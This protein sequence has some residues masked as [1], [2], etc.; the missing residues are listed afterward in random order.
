MKDTAL[1]GFRPAGNIERS[2]D[3]LWKNRLAEAD[4]HLAI[5]VLQ[6]VPRRKQTHDR[7]FFDFLAIEFIDITEA[8]QQAL[9]ADIDRYKRQWAMPLILCCT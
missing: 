1:I 9:I 4:T 3:V 7:F 2:P 8:L 6:V 5:I